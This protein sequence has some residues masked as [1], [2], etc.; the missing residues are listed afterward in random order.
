MLAATTKVK[1]IKKDLLGAFCYQ[2][3]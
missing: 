2:D 1:K 3:G